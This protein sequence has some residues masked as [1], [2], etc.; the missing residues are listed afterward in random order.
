MFP[1]EVCAV[2]STSEDGQ[3][4]GLRKALLVDGMSEERWDRRDRGETPQ[5]FKSFVWT[6]HNQQLIIDRLRSHIRRTEKAALNG[7]PLPKFGLDIS[8]QPVIQ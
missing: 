1:S 2:S 8:L 5:A 6:I 4:R 3:V 7:E